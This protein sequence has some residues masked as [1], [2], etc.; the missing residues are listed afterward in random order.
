MDYTKNVVGI[1]LLLALVMPLASAE[2]VSFVD[3]DYTSNFRYTQTDVEIAS[4]STDYRYNLVSETNRPFAILGFLAKDDLGNDTWVN[5]TCRNATY[6]LDLTESNAWNRDG[7]TYFE[8]PL[9]QDS[10]LEYQ[11]S[12]SCDIS[13]S[14]DDDIYLQTYHPLSNLEGIAT[15]REEYFSAPDNAMND[16]VAGT[17]DILTSAFELMRILLVITGVILLVFLLVFAWKLIEYFASR[18]SRRGRIE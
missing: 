18:I 5:L 10:S 9:L 3:F 4:G 17:A 14:G 13:V 2:S 1:I 16:I 8:L 6:R 15:T 12:E 11:Y 7:A